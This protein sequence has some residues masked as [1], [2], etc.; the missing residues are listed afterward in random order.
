MGTLNAA[1]YEFNKTTVI[2]GVQYR[3]GDLYVPP[4]GMAS[5]KVSQLLNQRIIRPV[6]TD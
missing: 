6:K 1:I 3:P 5:H 4:E 2:A